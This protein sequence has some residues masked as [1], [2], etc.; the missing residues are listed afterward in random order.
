[1]PRKRGNCFAASLGIASPLIVLEL[2]A[3]EQPPVRVADDLQDAVEHRVGGGIASAR[4][5]VIQCEHGALDERPRR[6]PLPKA[7]LKISARLADF[8]RS[9][10]SK[11]RAIRCNLDELISVKHQV[12]S[13]GHIAF[14]YA[15]WSG[16]TMTRET[17]FYRLSVCWLIALAVGCAYVL[18]L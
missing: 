17:L 18:T 16:G 1:L 7:K 5:G 6:L 10:P 2:I 9:D 11:A 15:T 4:V 14:G 12:R 13:V 8:S 3:R